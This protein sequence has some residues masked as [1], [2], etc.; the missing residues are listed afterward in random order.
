[1]TA[2]PTRIRRAKGLPD[3]ALRG[4]DGLGHSSNRRSS[5]RFRA[6][7]AYGP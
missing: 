5:P 3:A 6:A 2:A 1:M 7:Q 4:L